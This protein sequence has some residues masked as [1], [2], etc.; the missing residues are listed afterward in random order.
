MLRILGF[1]VTLT[2]AGTMANVSAAEPQKPVIEKPCTQEEFMANCRKQNARFCDWLW[3]KQQ[4]MGGN[5][6]R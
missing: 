4:R 3:D 5:C 2:L 1:I 6:K